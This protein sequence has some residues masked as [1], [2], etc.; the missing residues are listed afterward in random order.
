MFIPCSVPKNAALAGSGI[1]TLKKHHLRLAPACFVLLACW[2]TVSPAAWADD[3]PVKTRIVPGERLSDWL[4]RNAQP[5]ADTTALHWRVPAEQGPQEQLRQAV[6]GALGPAHPALAAWL[7]ALPLTGRLTVAR[8]DA[9]WLQAA[10]A[11]DPVLQDGQTVLLLPRP[12]QVSVVDAQGRIC[13]VP[14]TSG[15]LIADYIQACGGEAGLAEVDWAWLAQADGRTSQYGVAPWS[16]TEQNEPGSGAWIWAPQRA[17]GIGPAVSDNL[18]RFLATQLPAGNLPATQPVRLGAAALVASHAPDNAQLSASDWGEIGLLQT[19]TARMEPAGAARMQVGRV[20]PYTRVTMMFQPLDWL[21]AGFRYT[22]IGNRLYGATIA[23]DQSYK[24]K[25]ID[26]KVRLREE[27]HLWPQVA[28]GVRDLGGTGLFSAEY[29]VASKRWGNWDAS[30]GLG[31]GY[32]GTSGNVKNPLGA[33]GSEFNTRTG[34]LNASGGTANFQSM[35]HGPAALFGGVQWHAPNS[36]WLVKLELDGNDY[37]HEPLNNNQTARSPFNLGAVYSY[38]PNIDFSVGV[39]RGS[40]WMLGFTM[41]G[42]LNKLQTPKL[43]DPALPVL[44]RAPPAK[45]EAST[46]RN[47]AQA[48]ELHTGWAVQGIAQ[49]AGTATLV[50]ET[51]EAVHLQERVDRAVKTLDLFA[52]STVHRF[53]LQLQQRGLRLSR[54]EVDRDEWIAQQTL[55]TAPALR[56]PVQQVEP[57]TDPDIAEAGYAKPD[58]HGFSADVSPS[59]S[60]ILGGPDSFLLYQ[61][62]V[63]AKLEQRFSENTWMSGLFNLRAL[64]NYGNFVYDAPSQLPRVRTLQRKYVTSSRA[65]MPL[66]QLTDV[67]DLGNGHYTS[68]YAGMLES[69]YGGVGGE[70]LYRPWQSRFAFGVDVNRVRQRDFDQNLQFRDYQVTTGHA[71]VYWDTGWNGIEVDLSAG[72]Y[73]AGDVGATVD[74]KRIFPNGV[75]LGLWATKTNVSAEQFGEGSFDKGI[76][77]RIPL[78]VLSPR[79]SAGNANIV[80]NPLTRD[81][82]ARLNRSFP[83]YDLTQQR[84]RRTW[85][86]KS[87]GKTH[88]G[89]AENNTYV[90]NEPSTHPL[91]NLGTT[92]R[93]LGQ[94]IADTPSSTWLWA[95]GAVLASSLLDSAV[96]HRV[97]GQTGLADSPLTRAG[98]AMPYALI[99][100]TGLLY[101]GIAGEAASTTAGTAITAA[102]YTLGANLLTR[103]AFGRARPF[104]EKGPGEFNGFTSGA[105]RSGFASNHVAT[106]FALVTPFAQQYDM[107]WLYAA[108][109]TTGLGRIADREHWL[110]DTVAGAFMG[111]AIGSMLSDQQVGRYKALRV[112]A[113][114]NHVEATW[115]F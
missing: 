88:F 111:Y 81:G 28:V 27:T 51:D 15:A 114:P 47:A 1:V 5:G 87:Y 58:D 83:L 92:T 82:G 46:W 33:L 106:A 60:Q 45:L 80:W 72:R 41:H 26:L 89:S 19:P 6:L 74:V 21:E 34:N 84:D 52:P 98:N 102:A 42:A 3:L 77:V 49:Q 23:G 91:G 48:V 43:L 86:W 96:D 57:G 66:L 11:Q 112:T 20:D 32:L 59:Y 107:P 61:L 9:R 73:L 79:S 105:T 31:W 35:F 90:V 113:S 55:A 8:A 68:L 85:S 65:T 30:L 24:D 94:Q 76:Y 64:D 100:G 67:R 18:I 12:A 75:S 2:A 110:S 103:Y 70:W 104:E 37:Q 69:M 4:L 16:Q 93:T 54:V 17:S 71:T 95:G 62:G 99:A 25:S 108:A 14:H 40:R 22:D 78:D 7:A 56:L 63:Q 97:A 109:A 53:V 36:P 101:T 39:E 10:P 13:S 29:L 44:R 50:A 115:S 38:S